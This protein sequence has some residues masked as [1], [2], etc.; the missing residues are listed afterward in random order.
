M[1]SAP[2]RRPGEPLPDVSI[3]PVGGRHVIPSFAHERARDVTH[4]TLRSLYSPRSLVATELAVMWDPNDLRAHLLPDLFVALD[5]GELDPVYGVLRNQ[6]RIW[7]E[8]G[9]P[10]LVL[11]MAS[12]TTFG[13]DKLGKKED[14][15][16]LGIREYV[17][18]DPL[19][20]FLQPQLQ[21]WRLRGGVYIAAPADP[22]GAVPSIALAGYDWL[23]QGMF[24]RLRDRRRGRIVPTPEEAVRESEAA[25]ARE[26][27]RAQAEAARAEVEARARA[28]AEAERVAADEEIARLREEVA[29]LRAALQPPDPAGG[30]TGPA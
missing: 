7:H 5:A 3:Y 2:F 13:R 29:R 8:V 24:L 27:A 11:E 21:V 15:A 14:Y 28:Q 6:Y 17:Q 20:D 22:E 1:A 23:R 26:A 30:A 18:F 9:P 25:R 12:R 4:D 10:D 16:A 19:G